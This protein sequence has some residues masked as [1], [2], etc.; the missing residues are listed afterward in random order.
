MLCSVPRYQALT[1]DST[2]ATGDVQ[3]GLQDAQ[4]RLEEA[5]GRP[6]LLEYG[7]H[8]EVLRIYTDADYTPFGGTGTVYPTARPIQTTNEQA[9][10]TGLICVADVI[11]GPLPNFDLANP[12][13]WP[14]STPLRATLTYVGGFNPEESDR[15]SRFFVPRCI[16]TD[17]AYC[18]HMIL[19]PNVPDPQ[20]AGAISV[21]S[22]DEGITYR[23]PLRSGPSVYEWSVETLRY[24]AS[25]A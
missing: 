11:Y 10:D 13:S 5:L 3:T 23:D 19:H 22:G 25:R 18:A 15:S 16:E 20:L 1:G 9:D 4:S 24:K 17:L 12:G 8:T 21:H 14:V 7:T 6:G 2:S